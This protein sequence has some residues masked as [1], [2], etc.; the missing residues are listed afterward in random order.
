MT[1]V[2]GSQRMRHACHHLEC[3]LPEDQR[4]LTV[5]DRENTRKQTFWMCL[6][7]ARVLL[8]L[9]APTV[10]IGSETTI[11]GTLFGTL[12]KVSFILLRKVNL[13]KAYF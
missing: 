8:P 11:I 6:D 9:I 2:Y 7:H 3:L 10:M 5:V 13:I 1:Y 4:I 12:L